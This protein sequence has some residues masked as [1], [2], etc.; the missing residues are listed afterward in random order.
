MFGGFM[1]GYYIDEIEDDFDEDDEIIGDMDIE[2]REDEK[3]NN[4]WPE[5]SYRK[6]QDRRKFIDEEDGE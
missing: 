1:N 5:M 2:Y 4:I 6:F 3:G